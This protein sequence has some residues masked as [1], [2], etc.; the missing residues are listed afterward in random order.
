MKIRQVKKMINNKAWD[1]RLALNNLDLDQK[2][3]HLIRAK[4]DAL[5]DLLID[6]ER[7]QV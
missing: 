3:Q 6:I 5:F 4:Q 1:Y 7:K 2:E